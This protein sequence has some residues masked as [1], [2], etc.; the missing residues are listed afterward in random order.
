MYT[1]FDVSVDIDTEEILTEIPAN[2]LEQELKRRAD[3]DRTVDD[4]KILYEALYYAL[5]DGNLEQAIAAANPL[6]DDTIG[7]IV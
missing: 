7:R 2:E 6:L 1:T 5:R 3:T 4:S